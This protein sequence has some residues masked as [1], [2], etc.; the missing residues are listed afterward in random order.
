MVKF[1]KQNFTIEHIDFDVVEPTVSRHGAQLP[2][3][4]RGLFVGPSGSGK[5]NTL[6]SLILSPDG[7]AFKNIYIYSKSLEQTKYRFLEQVLSKI[8]EVGYFTF[9][10]A[11]EILD[12]QEAE[13]ESLFICD[14]IITSNHETVQN[15]FSRGRHRNLDCIYLSQSYTQAPK[16][17]AR[18][19]VNLL[20]I[21]KSDDL[22]LHSLYKGHVGGD[23]TFQAFKKLCSHAWRNKFGF[24]VICKDND[25]NKGRY[26]I[27]F[28]TF[29]YPDRNNSFE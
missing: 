2:Q 3:H 15:Y 5:T 14:D 23:M 21:F 17:N 11:S 7:I 13:C 24:L 12:V 8:P 27:G 9:S 28:E 6:V 16:R 19:N 18:D 25:I 20:A 29:I 4:I 1:Q 26:R 22:N 10:N